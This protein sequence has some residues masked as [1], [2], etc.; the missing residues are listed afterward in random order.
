MM[1][2]GPRKSKLLMR[3]S[4]RVSTHT[5]ARHQTSEESKLSLLS[6]LHSTVCLSTICCTAPYH[7]TVGLT[8]TGKMN[9]LDTIEGNWKD[10]MKV[11]ML[12]VPNACDLH[13]SMAKTQIFF[14]ELRMS[15]LID[16]RD[17][18]Q[19]VP[20]K[21]NRLHPST[22]ASMVQDISRSYIEPKK[23]GLGTHTL[24]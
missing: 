10:P 11:D 12:L 5:C 1:L 7:N 19:C 16:W 6:N 14:M 21:R 2:K 15:F 22:T 20:H 4:G 8:A 13:F 24:K 23:E 3:I 17:Q 9:L 18:L